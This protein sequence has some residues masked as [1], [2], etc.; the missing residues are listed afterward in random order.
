MA[1]ARHCPLLARRV[2]LVNFSGLGNAICISGLMRATGQSGLH[3]VYFHNECPGLTDA[4][5]CR[6]A[7]LD[8][9]GGLYPGLWRR[10]APV[11]WPAIEQFLEANEIDTI[12]NL[13]NEG[14]DLDIGY[15]A[16]KATRIERYAFFDLFD[17]AEAGRLGI[18][19]LVADWHELFAR[20]GAQI[21]APSNWLADLVAPNL[22]PASEI[23]FFPTS[24]QAVKRWRD[25]NWLGLAKVLYEQEHTRFRIVSGILDREREEAHQLADAMRQRLTSAHVNVAVYNDTMRFLR[26]LS[27]LRILVAN[28]TAAVHA[29]AALGVPTV[30][31]YL[32]T[33]G[34]IWGG[35]SRQF[36]A[37][38]SA[39]GLACPEQK[40]DTG[41]CKLYYS[42]CP[43]PCH[44]SVTPDRVAQAIEEML[45]TQPVL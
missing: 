27:G 9:L 5:F 10:F 24:S 12:I 39:V 45:P 20:A 16:F 42:G 22:S 1:D 38:Q 30:G 34:L 11:D 2:M 14:P 6:R 19:N 32:A 3:W 15:A 25:E 43:A 13:R 35:F 23:G 37:V 7:E 44:D 8:M 26:A 36:V 18:S 33:S 40:P 17:A 29:G 28:D 4:T 31:L 41:N 21:D